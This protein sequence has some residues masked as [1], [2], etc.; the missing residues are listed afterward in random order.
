M[1]HELQEF[2]KTWDKEA[3]KTAQLLRTLPEGKYD[4]RPYPEC[5]SLGEMAWHLAEVD[6]YPSYWIERN[7]VSFE[8]RAP[9]L[10][11]PKQI[12]ELAPGFERVHKEAVERLQKANLPDLDRQM[13]FVDGR[14]VSLSNILWEGL[15]FHLIHHRGQLAMMIR[16]A[17]GTPPGMYGPNRE[18][19]VKMRE[20]MAKAT[21]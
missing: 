19:M 15:L 20:A 3:Q 8:E 18:E 4:F 12:A 14:M 11:R 1:N 2:F 16:L 6:A 5:R 17:A 13:K 9:G 21:S 7:K 10:E